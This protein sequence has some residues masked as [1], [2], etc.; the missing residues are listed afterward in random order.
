M[1][2][3][4]LNAALPLIEAGFKVFPAKPRGKQPLIK[5]W[6][7][8]ASKDHKQ[9]ERWGKQWRDANVAIPTGEVNNLLAVD[10]DGRNGGLINK[11]II[12]DQY[13]PFEGPVVRTGDGIHIY[14]AY[15]P[16]GVSSGA[17]KIARGIDHKA[18]R[19][20][21]LGPGSVHPSG[22]VYAL[23]D[24]DSLSEATLSIPQ[25]WLLNKMRGVNGN[26]VQ[27][28]SDGNCTRPS[29]NGERCFKEGKRNI[30]IFIEACKLFESGKS[31]DEALEE[32]F[33]INKIVCDP[34]LP[35]DEVRRTVQSAQK[36]VAA[37]NL[38]IADTL[39]Q[40][41]V[42]ALTKDSTGDTILEALKQAQAFSSYSS[43]ADVGVLKAEVRKKLKDIRYPS[44]GE[45]VKAVFSAPKEA[46]SSSPGFLETPEPWNESVE[47]AELAD[48]ISD[49]IRQYIFL[50][51]HEAVAVTLFIL[52]GWAIDVV[53][54]SPILR[55]SSG[56]K[57]CGKSIL[58]TLAAALLSRS[59]MTGNMTVASL[60][61]AVDKFRATIAL[62]E[63]D[64]GLANDPELASMFNASYMKATSMVPRCV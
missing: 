22:A 51:K 62:D 6:Q 42:S 18:A 15:P 39:K 10:C 59:V 53:T 27:S 45:V 55:I 32:V 1:K 58:L 64:I 49:T 9:I 38:S 60:Y 21:V 61:R 54:I 17:G 26:G 57:G 46:D 47:G 29:S 28:R 13:G 12:E 14:F 48:E 11:D 8:K 50:N 52:H 30:S 24:Y 5:S 19:G 63:A 23:L 16:D 2:I 41:G 20:Y 35:E 25:G 40:F 37:K 56:S 7:T 34:A 31:F 33:N 36:N 44:P 4:F 43:P 3:F